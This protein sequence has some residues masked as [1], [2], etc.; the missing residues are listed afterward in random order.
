M[1]NLSSAKWTSVAFR[2]ASRIEMSRIRAIRQF[3]PIP[4][5]RIILISIDENTLY[6]SVGMWLKRVEYSLEKFIFVGPKPMPEEEWTQLCEQYG[7]EQERVPAG[8]ALLV[9]LRS[10]EPRLM[11]VSVDYK[12]PAI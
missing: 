1:R 11:P 9:D 2:N 4:R 12:P 7:G 3:D 8:D 6:C 5:I 10:D